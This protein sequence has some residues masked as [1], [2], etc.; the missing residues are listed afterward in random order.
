MTRLG[1]LRKM[2]VDL[3]RSSALEPEASL[4]NSRPLRLTL[5]AVAFFVACPAF[6]TPRLSS[7][8]GQNCNL[9]HLNPTGGGL[10]SLYAS[11]YLLPTRFAMAARSEE[12]KPPVNPQIGDDVTIGADLRVFHLAE[13]D[14]EAGNNFVTMQGSLYLAFQLDPKFSLYLHE[15]LGQGNA[16]AY[17][18]F[19]LGYVFPWNGYLKAGKFV[20]AFGWKVPDHRAFTR[21]EF[22]FLP[23]FPPHSDTGIEFGVSPGPF[24]LEASITNGE[25]RSPRDS[26]RDFAYT[27]RGSFRMTDAVGGLN[28][29]AGASYH[30]RGEKG[31]GLWA[32][33]PFASA[34]WNRLTW[35]GE[36]DWSHAEIPPA[37]EA[38]RSNSTSVTLSQELSLRVVRGFDA[39]V[40]HDFFD[41]TKNRQTGSV[42][43]WGAGLEA[44]PYSFLGIQAMVYLFHPDDGPEIAGR[45]GYA[46]DRLQSA[47]QIHV[48]Y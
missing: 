18:I 9:C 41:P 40:S 45:Y 13:E 22:V 3:R 46:D 32:G 16:L 12:E 2:R 25:F 28:A 23:T 47:V 48:L 4:V 8:V 29:V 15:E 20:P 42:E 33:G 14:R 31:D 27:A 19:G 21:R 24:T 6:A 36:F 5:V 1:P 10:R 7:I 17:E 44:L 34:T 39:V 26:D 30:Q 11:Q 37:G 43:R 38:P 35:I